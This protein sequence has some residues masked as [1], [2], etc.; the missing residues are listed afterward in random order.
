QD[1]SPGS[2]NAYRSRL[3]STLDEF[4][5]HLTNPLGYRPNTPQTRE[6][7]ASNS[8]GEAAGSNSVKPTVPQSKVEP[9]GASNIVPIQIRP[10]VTIRIQGLPF[11][12]TE[13]EAK[14]IANVV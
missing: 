1:Y 10:D 11:D 2:L 5:S 3:R 8:K 9:P 14:R 12:L 13:A 7:R 4:E 6:R